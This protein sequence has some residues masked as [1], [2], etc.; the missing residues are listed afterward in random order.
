[1]VLVVVFVVALVVVFVV[2]LVVVLVVALVVVALVVVALVVVG[3]VFEHVAP[4][5]NPG[6]PEATMMHGFPL[7]FMT[8][9][10]VMEAEHL[11]LL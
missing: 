4:L 6:I 3:M 7:G 5:Q 8:L 10:Q 1:V 9:S 11:G 2:A